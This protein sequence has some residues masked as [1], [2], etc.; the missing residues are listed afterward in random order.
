ME[1][2]WEINWQRN[3]DSNWESAIAASMEDA[4]RKSKMM[5]TKV[6]CWNV[7]WQARSSSNEKRPCWTVRNGVVN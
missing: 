4:E 6:G 5:A 2:K 3:K 1:A 7:N